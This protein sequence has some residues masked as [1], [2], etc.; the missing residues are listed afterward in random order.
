[1]RVAHESSAR[2]NYFKIAYMY[3]SPHC[4]ELYSFHSK[5][6]NSQLARHFP[7]FKNEVVS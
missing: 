5:S 4:V 3:H 1:M 2:A 6:P 7:V